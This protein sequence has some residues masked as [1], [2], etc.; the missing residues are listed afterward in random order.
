[1]K[2]FGATISVGALQPLGRAL[3]LPIAVLPVAGLLLRLGQ[4]DL[5]NIDFVAAAG[6]AIFHNLGLLFAIG[7]AVGFA[8]DG[9]GAAGLAGV[10]CFLVATNGA[11]A[12]I[13]APGALTA[14]VGAK[15][16]ALTI[17]DYRAT[18]LFKL[19][20]PLGILSGLI[21][22]SFYNRFGTIKLPDYLAFFGG[23][24]FVPIVSGLAGLVLA[25]IFGLGWTS[26]DAAINALSRFIIGAGPVG[27]FLYGVLN[28]LLIVTG[29]H[30]ILNN[31]VWFIVGDYHGVTG[32]LNRF[33]AGDPT[34]GSFMAGFFPVM[35]FGLPAA[36]LA[37]YHEARPERRAETG[38]LL[39]S[40]ALT[41]FLTGVT[42]PIEFSF[43]FLVPA[44][45]L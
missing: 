33:F 8:K 11:E 39:L 42:E 32:D 12:L 19:S 6:N 41:V 36:C 14:G 21:A 9:N 29:L 34:A 4:P 43:M 10:V 2:V 16:A 24:R 30:H 25:A 17:A 15:T 26:L 27:L 13:G 18:A 20:V 37:M 28:R 22:G 40:L 45:Y 1:M 7:V 35:M 3:M 31:V 5:L 44:L 38:G 23:R